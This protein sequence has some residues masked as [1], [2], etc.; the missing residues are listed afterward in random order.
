MPA[1]HRS[2]RRGALH[3]LSPDG[4]TDAAASSRRG[5][6]PGKNKLATAGNLNKHSSNHL[7]RQKAVKVTSS[8]EHSAGTEEEG[9]GLLGTTGPPRHHGRPGRMRSRQ[10]TTTPTP[11]PPRPAKGS[12][13]EADQRRQPPAPRHLSKGLAASVQPTKSTT[14]LGGESARG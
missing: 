12:I 11:P 14:D 5:E 1:E 9:E 8:N 2:R 6:T 10:P 13:G 7:G 3:P 4:E